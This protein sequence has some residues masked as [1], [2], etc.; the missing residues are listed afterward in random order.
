MV[1]TALVFFQCSYFRLY[2]VT[3]PRR[4]RPGMIIVI[5]ATVL[6]IDPYP[7]ITV[8]AYLKA[9]ELD[10]GYVMTEDTFSRVGTRQ[11]RIQVCFNCA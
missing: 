9:K 11:L 1:V 2:F 7:A 3:A 5:S 8:R 10:I 6:R 4:V